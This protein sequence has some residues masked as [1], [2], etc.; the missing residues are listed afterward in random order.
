[1]SLRLHSAVEYTHEPD[2]RDRPPLH[3]ADIVDRLLERTERTERTEPA[4]GTGQDLVVL[5]YADA[6]TQGHK[7]TAS[8]LNHRTGGD[9][10]SF[11]LTA[12]G[13][14]G[15][16]TALRVADAYARTGR[17]SSSLLALVECAGADGASAASGV[18]LRLDGR[19]GY[20]VAETRSLPLGELAD[21]CAALVPEEG[22]LLLVL[23]PGTDPGTAP[24]ERTDIGVPPSDSSSTA[25]WRLLARQAPTWREQYPVVAL[26]A[27]DPDT[28][29]GHLA[30]LRE[31]D[32]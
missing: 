20:G 12:R 18:L 32:R 26:C 17:G 7:T 9:A 8:H 22:R 3:H 14:G 21:A 11:A 10:H 29:T 28:G 31:L 23:G 1:M 19:P 16:F 13:A 27:A 4:A 15:P 25:V 5:V 30:V 24:A 6:D 2:G